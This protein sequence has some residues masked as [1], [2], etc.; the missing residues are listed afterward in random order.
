MTS[1]LNGKVALIVGDGGEADGALAAGLAACG[2]AVGLIGPARHAGAM[3]RH[4]AEIRGSGAKAAYLAVPP[5]ERSAL[6]GAIGQLVELLGPVDLVILPVTDP[7]ELSAV[8]FATLDES[9][10]AA[11]CEAPL[12]AMRVAMQ[13]AHTALRETGG[14]I[15]LLVPT[16]AI[17]GAEGLVAY[18]AVGEGARSLAK[19]AAR[20]WGEHG[21]TVNCLALTPEQLHPGATRA[22]P[23]TRVPQALD[24]TPDLKT[25]VAPLIASLATGPAIVTGATIMVDGGNLMSV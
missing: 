7:G 6:E 8:P 17:N 24:H 13:A 25:E 22:A 16:I 19:A 21:I 10:F 23:A 11:R 15:I 1:L 3:A 2:A 12:K 20:R 4:C 5:G 9:D 18:G 14:R